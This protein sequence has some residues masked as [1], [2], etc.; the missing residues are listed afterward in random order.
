[1][2]ELVPSLSPVLKEGSWVFPLDV[3][4][5]LVSPILVPPGA[6]S[7]SPVPVPLPVGAPSLSPVLIPLLVDASS[8][9]PVLVLEL[10][11]E[12]S[13]SVVLVSMPLSVIPVLVPVLL[14]GTFRP[15]LPLLLA[16][17]LRD[18]LRLANI[19]AVPEP[20]G[21]WSKPRPLFA[22]LILQTRMEHVERHGHL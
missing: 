1:M 16:E 2:L 12:G 3:R 11:G 22:F 13:F 18:C 14:L 15:T 8:L 17:E 21:S 6:P 4:G 10:E 7:L 5:S 20:S 9:S 19:P